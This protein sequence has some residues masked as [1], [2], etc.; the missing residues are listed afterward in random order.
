MEFKLI[1]SILESWAAS[2]ATSRTWSRAQ[3][4]P[5]LHVPRSASL[6]RRRAQDPRAAILVKNRKRPTAHSTVPG[7]RGETHLRERSPFRLLVSGHTA[8]ATSPTACVRY[9]ARR[10]A[11]G[12]DPHP[13]ERAARGSFPGA[14]LRSLWRRHQ[15]FHESIASGRFDART[16]PH[17]HTTSGCTGT[18]ATHAHTACYGASLMVATKRGIRAGRP[19]ARR[20]GRGRSGGDRVSAAPGGGRRCRDDGEVRSPRSR[21]SSG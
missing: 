17:E 8:S 21:E 14:G 13:D 3:S 10:I 5:L 18:S 9:A 16:I 4:C 20:R 2:P 1:G 12:C 6:R 11:G 19:S 15:G 7:A